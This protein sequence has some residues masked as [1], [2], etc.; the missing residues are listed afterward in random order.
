[1]FVHG[2][3]PRGRNDHPFET[4]THANGKFWPTDFLAEDMPFARVFV[5]GYNSNITNA[6]T[7]STA[8]IKDH[9]N[10]LLNLLDMEREPSMVRIL[11]AYMD[12]DE[13][14]CSSTRCHRKLFLSDTVS[15]GW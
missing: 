15:V 6:Q 14:T 1:V 10:T 2:L 4:W 7:M 3:N 13:L 5:Y 12:G 8:S 11:S 9:A